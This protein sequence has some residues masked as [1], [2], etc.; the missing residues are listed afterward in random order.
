MVLYVYVYIP[1][2]Y[3]M[4][5]YVG[6]ESR[7]SWCGGFY[8]LYNPPPTLGVLSL[9]GW[10]ATC[11]NNE[12]CVFFVSSQLIVKPVIQKIFVQQVDVYFLLSIRLP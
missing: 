10:S 2:R 11:M 3:C 8:A 9:S 12:R 1:Y 5:R 7:C 4:Y 6:I